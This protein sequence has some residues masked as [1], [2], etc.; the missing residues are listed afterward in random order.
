MKTLRIKK[1]SIPEESNEGKGTLAELNKHATVM[2]S[3]AKP[4]PTGV[5]KP[6]VKRRDRYA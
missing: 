1:I 2:D 4:I 5:V 3:L 6:A